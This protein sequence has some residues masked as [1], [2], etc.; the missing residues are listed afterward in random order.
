MIFSKYKTKYI[1]SLFVTV[2]TDQSLVDK[3]CIIEFK[4]QFIPSLTDLKPSLSIP[5]TH[6]H[7]VL[8]SLSVF[9]GPTMPWICGYLYRNYTFLSWK[10]LSFHVKWII[11]SPLAQSLP[12]TNE[13]GQLFHYENSQKAISLN[14]STMK[15]SPVG[16]KIHVTVAYY[17]AL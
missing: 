2:I 13:S 7:F 5:F 10:A 16:H 11:L 4:A 12:Q 9:S 14:F 1:P 6:I 8:T 3:E 15:L 17:I